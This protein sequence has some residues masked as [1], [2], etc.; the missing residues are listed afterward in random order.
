MIVV[1]QPQGVQ[2]KQTGSSEYNVL[3]M[4]PLSLN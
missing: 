4:R 3:Q 2:E 1:D